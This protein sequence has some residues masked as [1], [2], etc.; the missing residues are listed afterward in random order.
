MAAARRVV[1]RLTRRQREILRAY[2][3][4]G[5]RKLAADQL[6]ISEDTVKH[7][8]AT[9]RSK[10]QVDTTAQAVYVEFASKV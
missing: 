3:K 2:A 4:T 10:L 5:S 1:R 8:L 9:I 6:G 7:T